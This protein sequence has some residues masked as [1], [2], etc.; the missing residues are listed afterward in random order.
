V[1]ETKDFR[2]ATLDA[3]KAGASS[4]ASGRGSPSHANR[5]TT[6]KNNLFRKRSSGPFEWRVGHRVRRSKTNTPTRTDI[7]LALATAGL[8]A[9]LLCSLSLRTF[10]HELARLTEKL[11]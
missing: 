1:N 10:W 7:W 9:Y 6:S 8:I 3:T 2:A 11:T 4:M 5:A